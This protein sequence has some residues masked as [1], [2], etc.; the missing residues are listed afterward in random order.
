MLLTQTPC[1]AGTDWDTGEIVSLVISHCVLLLYAQSGAGKTSL[2]NASLIP[3]LREEGFEVFPSARVQGL[4]PEGMRV[5]DVANPFV[6][7]SLVSWAGEEVEPRTLA[8]A[9]LVEFL[10]TREHSIDDERMPAPRVII[11][12]QF[13]ELMT[14][15][16]NRW[17]EREGF[18]QQ[19]REA[20]DEDP[21]L[22]VVLS[23]R[24]DYIAEIDSYAHL[25]PEGLRTR[26][27][28][29]RLGRQSARMA[30]TG[31][32]AGTDRSFEEGVADNLIESLLNIQ[33]QISPDETVEVVGEHV[34]PVQLQAVCESLW[35]ALP[36]DVTLIEDGHVQRFGNVDQVLSDFYEDSVRT[37]ASRARVRQGNLRSWFERALITPAGTR[38]TVFRGSET[39]G[40]IP[41]RAVEALENLHLIRG[42]VRA[43]SRWHELTHDRFIE[44]IRNSNEGQRRRVIRRLTLYGLV[45]IVAI[46]AVGISLAFTLAAGG[47][48]SVGPDV[49]LDQ[50]STSLP[51]GLPL[52]EIFEGEEL[53]GSG[54]FPEVDANT[55]G[56][57]VRYGDGFEG[58]TF[59]VSSGQDFDLRYQYLNDG[60]FTVT[61]VLSS[62]LPGA[63]P[64][65]IDI[66]RVSV[67][68][69]APSLELGGD[70]NISEGGTFRRSIQVTDPGGDPLKVTVDYGDGSGADVRQPRLP[71][72]T[73]RHLPGGHSSG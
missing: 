9:T 63:D 69:V 23:M 71:L 50:S 26:F 56:G 28:L 30:I 66:A 6:F 58:D 8:D 5:S 24:E 14:A 68:N 59:E 72:R 62:V 70:E 7:N 15:Y 11:I 21:I 67:S 38:G 27:R 43:G 4:I 17:M 52:I 73:R 1:R 3:E 22:R 29:Q 36:P 53:S 12:D 41:N 32:L 65:L 19:L 55:A 39:T 13:E 44:P 2:I 33:V 31:P 51:S 48:E 37:A 49:R 42:E 47:E 46:A 10:R 57:F 61:V 54:S 35:R 60:E 34:E 16:P 20:L 45:G 64:D 40:G 18:F 25:L